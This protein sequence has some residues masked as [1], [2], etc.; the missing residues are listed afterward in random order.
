[1]GELLAAADRDRR[2]P[3]LT[4]QPLAILADELVNRLDHR[5]WLGWDGAL[6]AQIVK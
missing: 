5:G 1:M 6:V 4:K 2:Q 3:A